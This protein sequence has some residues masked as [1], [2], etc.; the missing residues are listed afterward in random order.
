MAERFIKKENSGDAGVAR[1]VDL[2]EASE[3]VVEVRGIIRW[4]I[5]SS[6]D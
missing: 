6:R 5:E 4:L 2:R 1:V 3:T